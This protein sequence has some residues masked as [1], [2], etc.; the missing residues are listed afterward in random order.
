MKQAQFAKS[1]LFVMQRTI[2]VTCRARA[3]TARLPSTIRMGTRAENSSV[4]RQADCGRQC[5]LRQDT[6]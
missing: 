4:K 6:I 2:P 3:A 1:W 5:R